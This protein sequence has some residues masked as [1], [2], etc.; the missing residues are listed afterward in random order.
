MLVEGYYARRV[1]TCFNAM[2]TKYEQGDEEKTFHSY[3]HIGEDVDADCKS[4]KTILTKSP[5]CVFQRHT[6][7]LFIDCGNDFIT[8]SSGLRYSLWEVVNFGAYMVE[9]NKD[10]EYL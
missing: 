6:H 2:E 1:E 8:T 9:S 10:Y 4:I 7:N 3:I 5:V